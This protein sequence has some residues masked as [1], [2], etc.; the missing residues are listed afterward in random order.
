MQMRHIKGRRDI[1]GCSNI[2]N[3]GLSLRTK[4]MVYVGKQCEFFY[5]HFYKHH[6]HQIDNQLKSYRKFCSDLLAGSSHQN[7]ITPVHHSSSFQRLNESMTR[8]TEGVV[9][10]H[11]LDCILRHFFWTLC[12]FFS[13]VTHLCVGIASEKV[14]TE[15][16]INIID[17]SSGP[18]LSLH[19]Y[20]S[21]YPQHHPH[22]LM[23]TYCK[24]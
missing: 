15:D 24:G 1:K 2:V 4:E 14:A 8:S 17:K 10:T 21:K 6:S 19:N 7:T 9:A 16:H 22:L 13:T 11:C 18:T 3:E 20:F 23:S 12:S 5:D